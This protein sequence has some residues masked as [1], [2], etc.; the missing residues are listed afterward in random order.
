MER[1]TVTHLGVPIGYVELPEQREWAGGWLDALPG[2]HAVR[3][4]LARLA[5]RDLAELLI[6]LERDASL[7]ARH[8]PAEMQDAF[9]EAA[10]LT[11]GLL[12]PVGQA[13]Q[14]AV[15]RVA[16]SGA[17]RLHV[18]AYFHAAAALKPALRVPRRDGG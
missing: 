12:D 18:R 5:R 1:F 3:G 14:A 11:F 15:V 17:S 8:V 13:V 16:D 4:V 9:A 2:V 10:G 6:A 7:I